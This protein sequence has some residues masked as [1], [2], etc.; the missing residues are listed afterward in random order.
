M[1]KPVQHIRNQALSASLDEALGRVHDVQAS[2]AKNYWWDRSPDTKKYLGRL[3]DALSELNRL[4][5]EGK[6][7]NPAARA[8]TNDLLEELPRRLADIE[9]E[10]ML[11]ILYEFQLLLV[12]HGDAQVVCGMAEG[13]LLWHKSDTSW[14]TWDGLYGDTKCLAVEQYRRGRVSRGALLSARNKLRSLY[15]ARRDDQQARFCRAESRAK[16]LHVLS[17]IMFFVLLAFVFVY[18]YALHP[19]PNWAL[20][21]AVP[22]AGAVGAALTGTRKARDELVR[23][24]AIFRFSSGLVAQLLVGGAA[25]LI[26]VVLVRARLTSIGHLTLHKPIEQIAIGFLAGLSEPFVLGTVQRATQLGSGAKK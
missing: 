25:A 21:F 4:N 2:D 3:S 18:H 7:T 8:R 24:S 19:H 9:P 23:E 20:T 5:R 14:L 12:D 17:I 15:R 22:L 1:S 13:E 10:S 6:L 11:A 16:N 26:V